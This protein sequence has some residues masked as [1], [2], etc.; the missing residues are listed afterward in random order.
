M[1]KHNKV[2]KAAAFAFG[3]T[4]A[5]VATGVQAADMGAKD[6]P[7]KF[8]LFEWTGQHVTAHITGHILEKMGY[9]VEFVTAGYLSSGAAVADGNITVAIEMWDNNLGEFYPKLISEGKIEDIGDVGLDAREGWMY[10]KHMKSACP[11]LPAWD[12]FVSCSQAFAMADTFPKGR[13]ITYPADWGTRS[14]DL[15]A[16]EGLNYAAVP[17]GSEGAMIAEMSSAIE[18]KTPLVMMFW[19]PHWYLAGL[20]AEWIDMPA[21]IV[22]KYDLV[23]PRTFNAAWPGMKDKWPAAYEFMKT[24]KISNAIQE[25]IMGAVTNDGGDVVAETQAW[26]DNNEALWK[27]LAEAAM[28]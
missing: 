28:N 7:I 20:D 11:G 3:V 24:F 27:P 8:S 10:P 18:A 26:V 1:F 12:A 19:A 6:E 16:G 4:A 9:T 14:A 5:L 21:D 17:P 15:V 23:P 25:P 2:V 22:K 13:L